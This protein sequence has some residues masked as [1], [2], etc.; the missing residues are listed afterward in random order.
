MEGLPSVC[1]VVSSLSTV[2]DASLTG[3]TA[4]TASVPCSSGIC[5]AAAAGEHKI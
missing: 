3:W 1:L 4:Q 2:S 5:N